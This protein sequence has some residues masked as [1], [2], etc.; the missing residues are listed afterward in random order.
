[1]INKIIPCLDIISG[2]AKSQS[3]INQKPTTITNQFRFPKANEW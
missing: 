1:M 2:K 3:Q